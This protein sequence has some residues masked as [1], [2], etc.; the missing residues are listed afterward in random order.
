MKCHLLDEETKPRFDFLVFQ[1]FGSIFVLDTIKYTWV[2][3]IQFFSV[4]IYLTRF[5]CDQK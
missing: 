5:L 4:Y 1:E 3:M 2:F